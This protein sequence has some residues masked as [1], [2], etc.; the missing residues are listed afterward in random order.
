MSE[1][2]VSTT[3]EQALTQV[4][5]L[6]GTEFFKSLAADLCSTGP[7]S[8][9]AIL[10]MDFEPSEPLVKPVVEELAAAA[11][12]QVEISLGVDAFAF[13]IDD[14]KKT[15]GPMFL[16]LP[17]GQ[18]NYRKRRAALASLA[19]KPTVNVSVLNQPDK[20]LKNPFS[21]RSHI[22]TAVV[23]DKV[24]LG[25]PNFHKTERADMVVSL[26]D[27]ELADWLCE[28]SSRIVRA[29]STSEV[30][31]G[32]D[33]DLQLDDKTRVLVD[34]GKPGQSLILD[35]A[36]RLIDDANERLYASFQFLPSGQLAER[37]GDADARGVTVRP[38]YNHPAQYNLA[39]NLHERFVKLRQSG[40]LPKT[41]LQSS[42]PRHAEIIHSKAMASEKAAIVGSHNFVELGVKY[43][44]PEIALRREDPAFALAVGSC[45]A[46]QAYHLEAVPSTYD[47]PETAAVPNI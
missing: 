3:P 19:Q 18:E 15:V 1:L 39:L 11:D 32:Q 5:I 16:P 35:E 7:D 27:A 28:L 45:L 4:E 10:T 6:S 44:T 21:G 25:G 2:A 13:L 26:E 40:I 38:F 43:G 42:L 24:Y 29:G 30:L 17:F 33:I 23:D 12:R 46:R 20:R 8:R 31:G 34:S 36:M 9:V 41:L 14:G 37:L 47:V 22:K